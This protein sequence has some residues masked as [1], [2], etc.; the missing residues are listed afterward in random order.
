MTSSPLSTKLLYE[1]SEENYDRTFSAYR[2]C[3]EV[4]A[5]HGEMPTD[6]LYD[7][8]LN[9]TR[10]ELIQAT[11]AELAAQNSERPDWINPFAGRSISNKFKSEE[12]R[13]FSGNLI[14]DG[15]HLLLRFITDAEQDQILSK[16]AIG[17]RDRLCHYSLEGLFKESLSCR[18]SDTYVDP[19]V[20]HQFYTKVNLVAHCVNLGCARLEDVR[21]HILQ[22]LTFQPTVQPHQVNALMILLKISGA[23]FAA[24]ADPSIMD[25]CCD[26]LKTGGHEGKVADKLAKVRALSLEARMI[27]ES[28]D[29][30]RFYNFERTVGKVSLLLRPSAAL[31]PKPPFSGPKILRRLRSRRLLG[32]RTW[33]NSLSRPSFPLPL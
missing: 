27:Y 23:T 4:G 31:H 10:P 15:V 25:R 26:F 30:R 29:H 20:H 17:L 9:G 33:R 16:Y 7:D 2:F 24:Y 28:L 32:S 12:A 19:K 13:V 3:V 18:S 21:D 8:I 11:Y 5:A 22:S 14:H 6:K 1:L